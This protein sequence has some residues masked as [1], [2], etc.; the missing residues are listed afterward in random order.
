MKL[1]FVL[2]RAG[3]GKT[4]RCLDEVR[5]R[6]ADA[7][8]GPPL[9]LLVPE[10]AT[11]TTEYALLEGSG[12]PGTMRAQALSFRRLA[13]RVMQETGGTALVP[14]GENGKNMLLFK[15]IH[16]H[17][18]R[19]RLFA[20]SAGQ[21]GFVEKLNEL[22]T[23]MKRYG[24][25]P[26]RLDELSG[27]AGLD[28]R[29]DLL[30]RKLHDIRLLYAELEDA[31]AGRYLDAED[32]LRFLARGFGASSLA[33]AEIWVDGFHGFTPAEYAALEAMIRSARG[34]TVALT[35]DRPYG[36]GEQPSELD[37]FRPTA[38]TYIRLREI[39]ERAGVPVEEPVVLRPDPA[40]RWA[41]S[42]MLAHLERHYGTRTPMAVP[43]DWLD[44]E[45]P[46]CGVVLRAAA[47][48]RAEVDAA[49][50]DILR[51]VQDDGLRWRDIAVMVRNLSDY[52]DLIEQTFSDYGI[53]FFLD[54][55]TV[56]HHHPLVEFIRSALE[57]VTKG[58]RHDA[59]IRCVK[60]ELLTGPDSGIDRSDLDRLEN[61]VLAAGIDGWRWLDPDGWRPLVRDP[62]EDEPGNAKEEDLEGFRRVLACRERVVGPLER[63]GK[64]LSR[65]RDV[66]SMCEAL[67]RLLDEVGAAD[68]LEAWSAEDAERGELLRSR[69]HRQLWDGVMH[70]LDQ[71]VELAGEERMPAGL[72]AGMVETGLDSLR[73][74]S[75]PPSVD[76]VLVGSLDRS[77]TGG[78]KAA[79]LLGA[80]EGVLP[81]RSREDG[82]LTERERERLG[83]AGIRLAPGVRRRLLDERF[84]IYAALTMPSRVL[85]ISY[86]AADEEGKG[87]YASELI[88]QV[89][90]LFPGIGIRSETGEPEEEA[91]AEEHLRHIRRPDRALSLLS[92]RLRRFRTDGRL[93][94]PWRDVY[95]WFAARPEWRDR[96]LTV[97]SSLRYRNEAAPLPLLTARRLYGD[98]LLASVSRMERFTACPFQ[99]FAAY[100]LRLEERRMHRLEAPDV[101]QLFHAALS[102]LAEACGPGLGELSQEEIAKAVSDIVDSLVPRLQSRILMSS[103]RYGFIAR[104]L[105]QT[106]VR[107]ASALAE[108]ARRGLFRP[109]GLEIAFGPGE[110]LPPLVLPAGPG[111]SV[112]VV[113]RIDRVDAAE[114]EDGLLLRIIDYKSSAKILRLEEVAFGLALQLVTYMDAL[115]THAPDWLGRPAEPAGVLYFHVHDPLLAVPAPLPGEEARRQALKR[116]R[117]RG[118][119]TADEAVV[120]MMDLGLET[121]RSDLVPAGLRKGGGFYSDS[122]VVT[123]DEWE[124]LRGAVRRTIGRI[125]GRILDGEVAIAPYRLGDRSPCAYCP[126]KPVCH[127]DPLIEGNGYR[128]IGRIPK[129]RIWELLREGAA[130]GVEAD[131]NGTER[132]DGGAKAAE[133]AAGRIEPLREAAGGADA[134]A[135][136][137]AVASGGSE[138]AGPDPGGALDEI[139]AGGEAAARGN[140]WAGD[141][142]E[143]D[144]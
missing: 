18:D 125:A 107:T 58:W 34:V 87:L 2:G 12:I 80:N 98:R 20:G 71:L 73:L 65:A 19:L 81:M 68:R 11:F 16:R 90:A 127:F 76:Q 53:P 41:D 5:A 61:Y 10:Q 139:A 114:T 37:L 119:L 13:F 133:A 116:F 112:E 105:K 31:L 50:R 132:T 118:L 22:L 99:H 70:L 110:R 85:W 92:G 89:G 95:N 32:G 83:D 102:R 78:V 57:T 124:V 135:D 52:A 136:P 101:G 3:T 93:P 143:G 62:L 9:I 96:L 79:Y 6:L 17:A 56:I 91:G 126:Y 109:V 25:T 63:F 140:D 142:G 24:V 129:E 48:R 108:H 43:A 74:G 115:L 82:V 117:T 35:L 21:R 28:A 4:R 26:D 66:R 27:D 111:R 1:R 39:A 15:L 36:P 47:N 100:G 103:S 67:Y 137:P 54:R 75:V 64:A 123:R 88:R 77:R 33:A 69:A 94:E 46:R 49:A 141:G 130:V 38:E 97:T 30:A 42:P 45:H 84:L 144:G 134:G 29:D 128:R 131:R 104:R 113:G 138:A 120:R 59:V 51:R 14:I 40:P 106:L 72:F 8:D 60:T 55:K 44:P 23:E 86:A 122:A 7:P 121:G